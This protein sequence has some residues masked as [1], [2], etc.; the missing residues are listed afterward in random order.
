MI[1][2]IS[3]LPSRT[4]QPCSIV[5]VT[6]Q[7]LTLRGLKGGANGK[8]AWIHT[9]EIFPSRKHR[10]SSQLWQSNGLHHSSSSQ[11]GLV[12]LLLSLLIVDSIVALFRT[13]YFLA[14]R[15]L[16]CRSAKEKDARERK[17]I[18]GI[19][20]NGLDWESILL[21]RK[22]RPDLSIFV[23]AVSYRFGNACSWACSIFSPRSFFQK[24]HA[25]S[26]SRHDMVDSP[27]L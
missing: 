12:R 3:H 17:A 26:W 9:R 25:D 18:T 7:L 19:L 2:F 21:L 8:A 1:Y 11:V 6:F 15:L 16:D 4:P 5:A 22:F 10:K 13:D 14:G 24:T 23:S 20:T 27:G